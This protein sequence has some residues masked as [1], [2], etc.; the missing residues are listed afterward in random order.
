MSTLSV[1]AVPLWLVRSTHLFESDMDLLGN[2][3]ANLSAHEN[4][5]SA[6]VGFSGAS[7]AEVI[8][9]VLFL[10]LI[11]ALTLV[12]NVALWFVVLRNSDL[13]KVSNYFILCLSGADILVIGLNLPFTVTA[14]I[15]AGWHLGDT[16][17]QVLGFVNMV[18]FVTSTTSL[19]AISLNRYFMIV[20]P[21]RYTKIY[22]TKNTAVIIIV[23]RQSVCFSGVWVF[24]IACSVPPLFG[25][26]RYSFIADQSFCFCSWAEHPGYTVF[27]FTMGFCLPST[28]M[29]FCYVGIWRRYKKNRRKLVGS[30]TRNE[31][32][33][34]Q[35]PTT[36]KT[37]DKSVTSLSTSP[38]YVRYFAPQQSNGGKNAIFLFIKHKR[39]GCRE[40]TKGDNK[41]QR[42]CRK[43]GV[44]TKTSLESNSNNAL[45]DMSKDRKS[46][47]CSEVVSYESSGEK[48]DSDAIGARSQPPEN[49]VFPL[50]E[51][52]RSARPKRNQGAVAFDCDLSIMKSPKDDEGS[53][54]GERA[55]EEGSDMTLNS[56]AQSSCKRQRNRLRHR[57][58]K[59]QRKEEAALTR[60]LLVVILAFVICWSPYAVTTM[61][62]VIGY[63][64]VPREVKVMSLVLGYFNSCCNPLVYGLMNKRFRDGFARLFH[65]N[66]GCN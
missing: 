39:S 1:R 15:Q 3:S 26:A 32:E 34:S 50:N 37:P 41:R 48:K 8:T 12:G 28:A 25:W 63:M 42:T 66:C 36:S 38:C 56:T 40:S 9:E 58:K 22:T 14:I 51:K 44:T 23:Y 43:G 45:D 18:T 30:P 62:Q 5:S 16:F 17:C 57:M 19:A 49:E 33:Q 6:L 27:M 53:T 35:E 2:E 64:H 4:V 7:K 29:T 20:H 11:F 54:E 65:L 21:G 24:S 10:L 61:G 59:K 47:L 46:D 31:R 13:R 52:K 60:S 55:E